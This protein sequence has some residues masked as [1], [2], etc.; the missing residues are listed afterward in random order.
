MK[1]NETMKVTTASIYN[2]QLKALKIL[3]EL[4]L[5]ASVSDGVRN[6]IA[7]GLSRE[8]KD[9]WKKSKE[10]GND[11]LV[12]EILSVLKEFDKGESKKKLQ[13]VNLPQIFYNILQMQKEKKDISQAWLIRQW[14][15]PYLKE[16]LYLALAIILDYVEEENDKVDNL[17]P[18]LV[19]I[20]QDNIDESLKKGCSSL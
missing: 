6:A 9:I 1:E 19:D 18:E 10:M 17:E 5:I 7:F 13:T 4:G 12:G 2:T 14:L 8:T 3:N 11:G 16:S 15:T 20:T